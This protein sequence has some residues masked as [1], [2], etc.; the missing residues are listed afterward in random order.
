[1]HFNFGTVLALT[2]FVAALTLMKTDRIWALVCL[3]VAGLQASIATGL[4]TIGIAKFR[5]DVV[6]PA[7]LVLSGA[8]CWTKVSGKAV[9]TAATT[10]TLIGAI[11]L[12]VGLRVLA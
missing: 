1:M 4:L 10:V 5:I 3:V 11:Q 9:V 8:I 7:L 6:L 2:A 12:L